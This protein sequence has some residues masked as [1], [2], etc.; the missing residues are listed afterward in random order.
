MVCIIFLKK[1]NFYSSMIMTDNIMHMLLNM[2][3]KIIEKNLAGD[4]LGTSSV[5]LFQGD[6]ALQY[7]SNNTQ[8][9]FP[10]DWNYLISKIFQQNDVKLFQLVHIMPRDQKTVSDVF[11]MLELNSDFPKWGFIGAVRFLVSPKALLL[12][13]S[14]DHENFE[15]NVKAFSTQSLMYKRKKRRTNE[16]LKYTFLLEND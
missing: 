12:F 13:I 9:V 2:L 10:D 8:H 6:N 16:F 7:D 11:V 1:S 3:C 14:Y 5:I 15:K 4:A